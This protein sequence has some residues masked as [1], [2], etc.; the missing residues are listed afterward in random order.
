MN[1]SGDDKGNLNCDN[2]GV[3]DSG[4]K[5]RELRRYKIKKVDESV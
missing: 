3:S 5:D 1:V 2:S 4:R